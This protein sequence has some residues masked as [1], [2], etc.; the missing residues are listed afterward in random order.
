MKLW[1]SPEV[2][3]VFLS[4]IKPENREIFVVQGDTNKLRGE[5]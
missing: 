5:A 4:I 2:T 3:Q 1:D